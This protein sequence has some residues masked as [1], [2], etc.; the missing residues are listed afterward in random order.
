MIV[1]PTRLRLNAGTN[2]QSLRRLFYLSDAHIDLIRAHP[3]QYQLQLACI[4]ID[5]PVPARLHWPF[6][7]SVN[8][9]GQP[10]PVMVKNLYM[11]K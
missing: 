1:P 7:A 11:L 2:Q 8:I 3:E 9:N 4:L 5:D 6:L 10:L